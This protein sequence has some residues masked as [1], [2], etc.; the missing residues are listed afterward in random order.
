MHR[1]I[2]RH[3][4]KMSDEAKARLAAQILNETDDFSLNTSTAFFSQLSDAV[5]GELCDRATDEPQRE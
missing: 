3:V 1:D 5:H 4:E 2:E